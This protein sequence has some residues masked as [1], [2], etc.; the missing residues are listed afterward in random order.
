M[1]GGTMDLADLKKRLRRGE[2]TTQDL[3]AIVELIENHYHC[4][5]TLD[6]NKQKRIKKTTKGT[7]ANENLKTRA[8]IRD[9]LH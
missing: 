1:G 9:R 3:L 2:F 4:Y 6:E 7:L 8:T 5:V